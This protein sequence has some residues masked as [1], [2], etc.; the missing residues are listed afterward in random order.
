MR[1][2]EQRAQAIAENWSGSGGLVPRGPRQLLAYF[3]ATPS[4]VE[5]HT[6]RRPTSID[7]LWRLEVSG[8][9]LQSG[10]LVYPGGVPFPEELHNQTAVITNEV[11]LYVDQSSGRVVGSYWWPDAV[12]RPIASPPRDE[13]APGS[14]C[15]PV[16][17]G[18]SID[19]E[20]SVPTRAPWRAA[21]AAR[22]DRD[23]VV[24][25]CVTETIPDPVHEMLLFEQGGLSL[26]ERTEESAEDV[27][28]FLRS[29]SPPYRRI[30]LGASTGIGRDPGRALGPQTWPWPGEL[31]WWDAGVAYELKGFVPLATLQDVAGTMCAVASL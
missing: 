29:H 3:P 18:G 22:L 23:E 24:V 15:D 28:S 6:G 20:L 7:G 16:D 5:R 26:R 14:V 25:F 1:V 2:E 31:R 27:A 30:A 9:F 10:G 4:E 12:R 21:L 19:F 13:F 11:W 8:R 17:I